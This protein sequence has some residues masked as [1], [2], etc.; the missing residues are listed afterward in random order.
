MV[1]CYD[2]ICNGSL[3]QRLKLFY[4]MHLDDRV[5]VAMATPCTTRMTEKR[6]SDGSSVG[7][8]DTGSG[9]GNVNFL[10]ANFLSYP[11]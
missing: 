10:I 5:P 11:K 3:S 4:L 9:L 7:S 2:V 8:S 1:F 6:G